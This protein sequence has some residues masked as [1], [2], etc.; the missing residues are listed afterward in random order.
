MN[1]PHYVVEQQSDND[2]EFS[3][4]VIARFDYQEDADRLVEAK[5]IAHDLEK[6]ASTN[7]TKYNYFSL[8]RDEPI[9]LRK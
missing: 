8:W 2:I 4:K 9:H 1:K 7:T 3:L 5:Q 6:K